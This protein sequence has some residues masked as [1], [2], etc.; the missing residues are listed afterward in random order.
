[1]DFFV[2]IHEKTF[3]GKS[4]KKYRASVVREQARSESSSRWDDGSAPIPVAAPISARNQVRR[5]AAATAAAA[6][7]RTLPVAGVEYGAFTPEVVLKAAEGCAAAAGGLSAGDVKG[8]LR[9][10]G[11][12][13]SGN[14]KE[15]R[16]R[17]LSH[18]LR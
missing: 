11:M 3:S 9:D 5:E 7:R 1:M 12:D 14:T 10:S 8:V 15:C 6:A 2:N 18:L 13:A 4:I 17:L 16:A